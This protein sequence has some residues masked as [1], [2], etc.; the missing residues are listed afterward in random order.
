M[1]LDSSSLL[2]I[3]A[4][5]TTVLLFV[6]G[7]SQF[8]STS[9]ESI[10]NRDTL[11]SAG[12]SDTY[13]QD[14][15]IQPIIAKNDLDPKKISLGEK[16]F[17]DN[18]LSATDSVSCA[19]CHDLS[20]GGVDGLANSIGINGGLGDINSPTVFNVALNIAQFWDGRVETLDEQ[21]DG[22]IHH[23]KELG[24]NWPE[25]IAKL[26]ADSTY[27]K[28]FNSL[29]P[30]GITEAT[31]KHAIATF[32]QSLLTVNSPFDRY[33]QGDLSAI[34]E[35]AIQGYE[36]FKEY[37]CV[38]CHQG[39]NVGGNLY[40]PFGIMGDYFSDRG[41]EV[42]KNDLGRFNV[43]GLE[44]DKFVFR[45]PSLRLAP[46]TAP[47]FHDGSAATLKEAV[48]IMIKYQIGRTA[49][50]HD[51]ELIIEF[52]KSLVGEYKGKRLSL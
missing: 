18:R 14:N 24:T 17:H 4:L 48:R 30:E 51:E 8:K 15:P 43:T 23:P 6:F 36:M 41:L 46:L 3:V 44:E 42:T 38:A 25:I 26:S 39:K 21:I 22:P 47:Y 50:E 28:I 13:D 45:V 32:E 1:K 35:N 37:G 27:Q 16:L 31:I 29:Y 49:S 12:T 5:V 9:T 10:K 11:S 7:W 2:S 40:Q 20:R 34:S 19:S 52:L 33:L